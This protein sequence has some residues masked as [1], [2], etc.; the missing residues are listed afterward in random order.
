VEVEE[1]VQSLL[2]IEVDYVNWSW[3]LDPNWSPTSPIILWTREEVDFILMAETVMEKDGPRVIS[4]PIY[5]ILHHIF[6]H[7]INENKL[8]N[9][10]FF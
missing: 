10:Y 8:F 6:L 3:L 5:I 2:Q 9:G 7:F 4:V 1:R